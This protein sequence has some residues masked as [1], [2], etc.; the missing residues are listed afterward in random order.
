MLLKKTRLPSAVEDLSE[1]KKDSKGSS[2]S[3]TS[4]ENTSDEEETP[5]L[6]ECYFFYGHVIYCHAKKMIRL[7]PLILISNYAL[8][9]KKPMNED[10]QEVIFRRQPHHALVS[11]SVDKKGAIQEKAIN[12]ET[13]LAKVSLSAIFVFLPTESPA[14]YL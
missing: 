11:F 13:P 8:Y 5:N 2:T 12:E 9:K 6:S 4:E 14:Q 1:A 7:L 10:S 3:S